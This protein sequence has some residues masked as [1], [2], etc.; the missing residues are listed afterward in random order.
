MRRRSRALPE[1][2]SE[3]K[4]ATRFDYLN[5]FAY[6]RAFTYNV[7]R[8]RR[9]MHIFRSDFR[10]LRNADFDLFS[11]IGKTKSRKTEIMEIDESLI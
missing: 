3:G 2:S 6:K 4:R 5:L 10:D 8:D 7:T 9:F 1:G 11:L